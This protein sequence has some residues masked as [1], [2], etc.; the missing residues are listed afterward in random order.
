MGFVHSVSSGLVERYGFCLEDKGGHGECVFCLVGPGFSDIFTVFSPF[1]GGFDSI[2][3]GTHGVGGATV[4]AVATA[5]V[6]AADRATV[7][8]LTRPVVLSVE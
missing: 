2:T 8:V 4:W 1:N 6:T 5:G 3:M 7:S